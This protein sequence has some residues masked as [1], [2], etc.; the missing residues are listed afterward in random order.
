MAIT[1][2]PLT[3]LASLGNIFGRLK[4][5][6]K[7]VLLSVIVFIGFLVSALASVYTVNEVKIGGHLYVTIK[8][9]KD[10]LEQFA[11]LK[12]D[13]NQIR[14]ESF[15]LIGEAD[16]DKRAQMKA[17]I[18]QLS[19][20]ANEKFATLVKLT[21][22][23]EKQ[24]AIGDAQSTWE[25][26]SATMTNELI[27]ALDAGDAA[28]ARELAT[29][30]Q[31]M[32]YDRFIEQISTM[33]D[34]FKMEITELEAQTGSAIRKKVILS[35]AVSSVIFLIVLLAAFLV[36]RAVTVP[37]NRGLEFARS[38]AEGNL[39]E[40]LEVRS[41]DEIGELSE[42]L[43]T[44][45]ESLRLMVNRVNA[46]AQNLA[47]VSGSIFTAAKT[48]MATT[49]SQATGIG[50]AS[51][52]VQAINKSA[53]EVS[54]N[55][56]TLSSSAAETSSSTLEM[57]ASVEEVALNMDNLL[58]AVEEV[59]SSI[60]QIAAAI[61]Q[62]SQG[63]ATLMEAS[64]TAA[65][66]VYEMNASISEVEKSSREAAAISGGVLQDAE[67]GMTSAADA[68]SGMDEIRRSSQITTEVIISLSAKA[69]NIGAILKV[70]TEVNEQTNLLALNAAIIAAQ[71][72]DHG[73]GFA[74]VAG[75]IKELA[76][77]TKNSTG[78]ISR[79]I[80]GVQV[81][82]KRAVD[83]IT[84]AEKNIEEGVLLSTRSGE[85]LQKI[86]A[87]VKSSTDQI[88]AIARAATEQTTG[89]SLI[90]E[91]VEKFS[92]MVQQIGT[93]TNEQAKVS[94]FI[95]SSVERMRSLAAQVRTSTQEQT[96]TS[97]TIAKSTE[98]ITGMISSIKTS[99]DIQATSTASI[100]KAVSGIEQSTD[101]NL[102]AASLLD[103]AVSSLAEQ[104]A[105]LQKEMGAFKLSSDRDTFADAEMPTS[106]Q[107]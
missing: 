62:I 84:A 68:I 71:A 47:V 19:L 46:S 90:N 18:D 77:R 94:D 59:S 25:E 101:K 83:A 6:D 104:T 85:A 36:T 63:T 7:M 27:P 69:D 80:N 14:A 1:F 3:K 107:V 99:C 86:V 4:M 9:T 37:L 61:K 65:S 40:T 41:Q 102:E 35:G 23:E 106:S 33:V 57:A 44:M 16:A 97:N 87:G 32:R 95:V 79:L 48:V 52:A 28:K 82:T 12:S 30:V 55:V 20:D 88:N 38:V 29:N 45:V 58:G 43:N 5:R 24:L 42:S 54:S 70:I 22:S 51:Q 17:V 73:K 8:Q 76:D 103:T 66:S 89:S 92:R 2:N 100:T 53:N 56:D 81:E 60:T 64:N 39:D 15:G 74:V 34:T 50:E 49:A 13:L 78:E 98:Q 96:K 11:L 75:E 26:F 31:K 72:G 91:S 105:V 67:F 10:A 93:A 21:T